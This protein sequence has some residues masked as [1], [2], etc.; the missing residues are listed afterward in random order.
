MDRYQLEAASDL[1]GNH[2]RYLAEFVW[3]DAP[4]QPEPPVCGS[5][6]QP[7]PE[8]F[9]CTWDEDLQVGACCQGEPECEC[10]QSDADLF[11]ALGC[12]FHNPNSPWNVRLRAVTAMQMCEQSAKEVA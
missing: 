10:H 5:C 11:D 4:K 12:E 7:C 2:A 1:A 6:S 3:G 9:P 8:L